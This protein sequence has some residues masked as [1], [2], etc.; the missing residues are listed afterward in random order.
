MAQSIILLSTKADD[1]S[2]ICGTHMVE[3]EGSLNQKVNVCTHILSCAQIYKMNKH[4][5]ITL[6]DRLIRLHPGHKLRRLKH[7][8]TFL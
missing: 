2:S 3:G 8:F 1:L 6:R 5:K 7:V 4:N